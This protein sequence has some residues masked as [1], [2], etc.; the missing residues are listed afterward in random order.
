MK[1]ARGIFGRLL[2]KTPMMVALLVMGALFT[3]MIL[4]V[5]ERWGAFYYKPPAVL[6]I[7]L[8]FIALPLFPV[9]LL[10]LEKLLKIDTWG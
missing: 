6:P 3:P 4:D 9:V 5:T 8:G 7:I 1:A 10:G 2:A